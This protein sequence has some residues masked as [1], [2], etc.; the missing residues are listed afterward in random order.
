MQGWCIFSSCGP[1]HAQRSRTCLPIQRPHP[2]L[3][4]GRSSWTA[5]NTPPCAAKPTPFCALH[6]QYLRV[7]T[8]LGTCRWD[9]HVV[10]LVQP[11][12][13]RPGFAVCVPREQCRAVHEEGRFGD[14]NDRGFCVALASFVGVGG[15]CSN[16][17][18]RCHKL[19]P[20]SG[21]HRGVSRARKWPTRP[22]L[23][24]PQ[25]QQSHSDAGRQPLLLYMCAQVTLHTRWLTWC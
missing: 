8:V 15:S 25:N 23:H 19:S 12:T 3:G 9:T 5:R 22:C 14:V 21:L 20:S 1:Q 11:A 13:H 16:E 10:M 18:Q 6:T 17:H 24:M 4:S 2:G 7:R